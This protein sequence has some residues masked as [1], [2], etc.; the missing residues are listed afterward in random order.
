MSDTNNKYQDKLRRARELS[1]AMCQS[2]QADFPNLQ[3]TLDLEPNASVDW[4]LTIPKQEKLKFEVSL[5][6]QGDELHLNVGQLWLEWFPCDKA[7]IVD[8]FRENIVGILNGAYR[9][10][11]RYRGSHFLNAEVQCPMGG[12]WENRGT[13]WNGLHA[14]LLLPFGFWLPYR[15]NFLQNTRPRVAVRPIVPPDQD[16]VDHHYRDDYETKCRRKM[17]AFAIALRDGDT[18]LISG[19]RGIMRWLCKLPDYEMPMFLGIRG[20]ESETDDYPIGEVRD[21]FAPEY[22]AELDAE[23]EDYINRVRDSL[24]QDCLE[25]IDYYAMDERMNRKVD[26]DYERS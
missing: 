22:L 21:K 26:E 13:S 11:E 16:G 10:V 12:E 24:L 6:L 4:M 9:V 1:I 18:D 5:N 17:V 2:I 15:E 20:I 23:M 8:E 14:L 19:V 3:M 25:I 7:E